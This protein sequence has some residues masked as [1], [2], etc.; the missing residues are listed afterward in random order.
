MKK[1]MKKTILKCVWGIVLGVTAGSGLPLAAQENNTDRP[2]ILWITCEDISPNLGCYGDR[3]ART[4]VLDELATQAVRYT[5]AYAVTGVCSPNRSCLITGIFPTTLGSHNMRSETRLPDRV[6]CFTEY[7]RSAGYYCSN[8]S[9]TDYNFPT[10]ETA[11][12]ESSSSAHWRKREAGQPFFSVFNF[13]VSHESRIRFPDE[14]FEEETARLTPGQRHD[15]DKAPVPPFHPNT[16]ETRQDWA[17]YHDLI[18]AMDYQVGD[19]LKQLEEDGLADETIVFFFSDHGAG[20][21]SYKKWVWESGL[22]VPMMVRFPEKHQHFSPGKSGSVTDR[23]VSFV[24][25]PSTVLSL[26]GVDIPEHSQGHA[27]LGRQETSPRKTVHAFRDRMIERYDTVRVVRDKQY[28]YIRN[29]MPHRSWSQFVSYTEEMPTMKV[30]RRLAEQQKLNPVQGR[31]FLSTKPTEELYDTAAD[32]HQINN[33]ATKP[34]YASIVKR[35]RQQNIAWMKKTHDLGLLPEYEIDR[36]A[37]GRT[38]YDV[39]HDPQLN[40]L[41]RLLEAA[42]LANQMNPENVSSLVELLH[43][44]DAAVRYWGAVGLVAL[45]EK[46]EPARDALLESL[47]DSAPNVRVAAAEAL[48]H[49]G[50]LDQALPILIAELKHETAFIRLRAINVLD[51]LGKRA[52]PALSAI[53]EAGVDDGSDVSD[54]L[55]RMIG[56]LPKKFDPVDNK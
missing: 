18:T 26:A 53:R 22:R 52:R 55:G 38:P 35:M 48:C 7:L 46:A 11:W 10:P 56:Y 4:P 45:R 39:A 23:L 16:P 42:D 9:K 32:P 14:K 5:N 2:N 24:D 12:N 44:D 31:Y 17:R 13:V 27:F 41:D 43:A 20:M 54:Y 33:L 15:P 37:A 6:K 3:Y 51:R 40:P 8:N 28:Q 50:Q 19:V 30:W 34:K 47:E 25:Y 29:Y 1:T 49:L 36:R 21:P